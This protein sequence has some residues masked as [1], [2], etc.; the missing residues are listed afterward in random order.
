MNTYDSEVSPRIDLPEGIPER[1]AC[2]INIDRQIEVYDLEE[3]CWKVVEPLVKP[4][5]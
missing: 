3:A 4:L 1:R 5:P 2:R